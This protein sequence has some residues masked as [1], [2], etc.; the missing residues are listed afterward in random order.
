MDNKILI[1]KLEKKL[2]HKVK[3]YKLNSFFISESN[4]KK[5]LFARMIDRL[6]ISIII[7]IISYLIFI[8]KWNSIYISIFLSLTFSILIYSI[9]NLKN[10]REIKNAKKVTTKKIVEEMIY[11]DIL[12]KTPGEISIYFSDLFKQ[13]GFYTND[14]LSDDFYLEV[15]NDNLKIGINILQYS[16]EYGVNEEALRKFFIKLNKSNLNKGIIITT[17]S[18]YED[19]KRLVMK[20]KK[21]K[22]I[23]LV[24]IKKLISIIK[25]TK[26]YPNKK[27]IENYILNKI[28][29]NKKSVTYYI[30]NILSPNKW[31]K[32]LISSFSIWI[33]GQFTD[34]H[35]YYIFIVLV[36]FSLG[37]VCL[38]RKTINYIYNGNEKKPEYS[39]EFIYKNENML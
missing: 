2:K 29:N 36:L 7:F 26:L 11:N 37:I 19:T 1:K 9:L 35:N 10:K 4:K 25:G 16:S 18:F 27:E 8:Y 21:Y 3:Q 14:K 24:D 23:E 13:L 5:T 20:L 17:S 34:F 38:L 32:Y 12:N 6:F 33:F 31:K 28:E 39:Y 15:F 22:N 30:K